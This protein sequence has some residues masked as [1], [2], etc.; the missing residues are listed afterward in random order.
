MAHDMMKDQQVPGT[1]IEALF[2]EA[3]RLVEQ[4]RTTAYRQINETL[5]RRN[6]MLGKLIAEEELN[7]EN[8]ALYGAAVIKALS[9][10]L[11]SAYGKGFSKSYLY[12]FLQ[13]YKTHPT[14]FQSV[15]GKSQKLLSCVHS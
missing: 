9:R 4:A 14:I 10:R 15:I 8:R 5:V 13:F 7:G 11:T 1:V 6:W 3:S 12:S 2:T